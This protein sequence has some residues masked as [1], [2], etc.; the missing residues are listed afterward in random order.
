MVFSILKKCV[1][2]VV[3]KFFFNFIIRV[4]PSKCYCMHFKNKPFQICCIK[5]SANNRSFG[6]CCWKCVTD[7]NTAG[8]S[9]SLPE[10]CCAQFWQSDAEHLPTSQWDFCER[11]KRKYVQI[12][13]PFFPLSIFVVVFLWRFFFTFKVPLQFYLKNIMRVQ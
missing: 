9:G 6:S 12:V 11:N 2:I 7:P 4:H 13:D 10:H 1:V 5:F 3:K 8:L